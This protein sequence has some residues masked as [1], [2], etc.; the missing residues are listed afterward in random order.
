[1]FG[2]YDSVC[3]FQCVSKFNL[4][5]DAGRLLG[6]AKVEMAI[7]IPIT[8]RRSEILGFFKRMGEGIPKEHKR[9]LIQFEVS[10]TPTSALRAKTGQVLISGVSQG[11]VYTDSMTGQITGDFF[12]IPSIDFLSSGFYDALEYLGF[13]HSDRK[14]NV[15]KSLFF[16]LVIGPVSNAQTWGEWVRS[17]FQAR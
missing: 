13:S 16:N 4:V 14:F 9:Y 6:K 15:S 8:D 7:L 3:R 11:S 5:S 2:S 12:D 17:F 10:D 1:V